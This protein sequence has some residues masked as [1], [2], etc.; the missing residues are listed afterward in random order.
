MST[1]VQIAAIICITILLALFM[2]RSAIKRLITAKNENFTFAFRVYGA[3]MW[4]F[5]G[6]HFPTEES[7]RGLQPDKVSKDEENTVHEVNE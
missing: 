6:N 3:G 2:I 7:L 1:S 5:R 4:I